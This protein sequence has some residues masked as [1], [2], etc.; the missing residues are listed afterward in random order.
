MTYGEPRFEERGARTHWEIVFW[1][2]FVIDLCV[3]QYLFAVTL[4]MPFA[5]M[6]AG[7]KALMA[8]LPILFFQAVYAGGLIY[9]CVVRRRRPILMV[10]LLIATPV[11]A[12]GGWYLV[13]IAGLI[14]PALGPLLS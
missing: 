3:M 14:P 4:V 6:A 5:L 9:A 13:T 8:W 7:F 12:Y 2:L 1:L 10:V 11:V